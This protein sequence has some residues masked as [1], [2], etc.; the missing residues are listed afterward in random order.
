MTFDTT[1]FVRLDALQMFD[2]SASGA[3]FTTSTGDILEASSYGPGVFRMR[4][5]PSTLPDYGL[6]VGR[7]KAC[8]VEHGENGAWRLT[9]GESTLE[10]S[11]SPLRFFQ[12]RLRKRP[13]R[14]S[15]LPA[16][17]CLM[18]LNFLHWVALWDMTTSI[19]TRMGV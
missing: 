16:V 14:P 19:I 1:A 9:S 10:I 5:G 12:N 4:V 7:A 15:P 11:S 17:R 3:S 13:Y 6:V 2:K 8:K 18:I